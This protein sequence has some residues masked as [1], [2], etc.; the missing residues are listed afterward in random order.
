MA[1]ISVVH[2]SRYSYN[3]QTHTIHRSA[4]EDLEML[5]HATGLPIKI[6]VTSSAWPGL[7]P[8]I[9]CVSQVSRVRR[10]IQLI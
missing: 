9:L 5:G 1:D 2:M 3:V 10:G 6:Q 4:A 7:L 8:V